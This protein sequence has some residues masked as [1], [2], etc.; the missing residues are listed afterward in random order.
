MPAIRLRSTQS[1]LLSACDPATYRAAIICDHP[2]IILH[3]SPYNPRWIAGASRAHSLN[4]LRPAALALRSVEPLPKDLTLCT[5]ASQ[6]APEPSLCE[7]CRDVVPP[8]RTPYETAVNAPFHRS[9]QRHVRAGSMGKC[10]GIRVWRSPPTSKH[11]RQG[12]RM[13]EREPVEYLERQRRLTAG[14]PQVPD[15]G[16]ARGLD[17]WP[18]QRQLPTQCPHAFTDRAKTHILLA[19]PVIDPMMANHGKG[20]SRAMLRHLQHSLSEKPASAPARGG[21]GALSFGGRAQKATGGK[22]DAAIGRW[23]SPHAPYPANTPTPN[24]WFPPEILRPE[25]V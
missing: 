2:A 20:F 12:R 22:I 19:I 8:K 18:T 24:F 3:L 14:E 4:V 10:C 23:Y 7:P 17:P 5:Q 13:I 25:N 15:G 1:P 21:G 6:S 9:G 16:Q 11:S